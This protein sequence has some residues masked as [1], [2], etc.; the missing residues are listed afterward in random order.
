[1]SPTALCG[2]Q[3]I[4]AAVVVLLVDASLALAGAPYGSTAWVM[5]LDL[6]PVVV[7]GR[8]MLW[9]AV[10]SVTRTNPASSEPRSRWPNRPSPSSPAIISIMKATAFRDIPRSAHLERT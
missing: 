3:L 2:A 1:L 9:W 4:P 6:G 8:F 7:G 10:V 5:A